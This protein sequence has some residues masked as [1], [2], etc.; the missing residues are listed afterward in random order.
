[1]QAMPVGV[2]GELYIGGEGVARGYLNQ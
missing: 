2:P 1:M